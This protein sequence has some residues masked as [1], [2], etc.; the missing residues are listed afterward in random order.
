[1]RFIFR[2]PCENHFQRALT[3]SSGFTKPAAQ[4]K[5]GKNGYFFAILFPVAKAKALLDV[6]KR[7]GF[8]FNN[9][10]RFFIREAH[11]PPHPDG[12]SGRLH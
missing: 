10:L 8:I 12:S 6:R 1:M 4:N 11:L 9:A 7:K 5:A 3:S 2:T